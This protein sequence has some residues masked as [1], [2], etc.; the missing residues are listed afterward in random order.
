MGL[1]TPTMEFVLVFIR[2]E[3]ASPLVS[4]IWFIRLGASKRTLQ[5]RGKSYCG[6]EQ[7]QKLSA[8]GGLW[9]AGPWGSNTT[10]IHWTKVHR[11]PPHLPPTPPHIPIR[12]P[13]NLQS[14][15]RHAQRVD[16]PVWSRAAADKHKEGLKGTDASR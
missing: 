7:M 3:M 6:T 10:K 15:S 13:A 11:A 1:S 14:K 16:I 4:A 9:I 2:R 12:K 8:L 5:E